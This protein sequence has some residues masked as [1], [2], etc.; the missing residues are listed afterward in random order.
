MN[1]VSRSY[2]FF[3]FFFEEEEEQTFELLESRS[4]LIG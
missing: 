3:L 1:L 2:Y 4:K